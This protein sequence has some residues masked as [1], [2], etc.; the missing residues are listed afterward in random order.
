M[1]HTTS[2]IIKVISDPFWPLGRG[3]CHPGDNLFLQDENVLHSQTNVR[4]GSPVI[5]HQESDFVGGSVDCGL[6]VPNFIVV[7]GS[8]TVGFVF[9]PIQTTLRITS[10]F[11]ILHHCQH[12]YITVFLVHWT[13]HLLFAVI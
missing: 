7:C 5:C 6:G 3:H 2:L 13:V 11:L 4:I 10:S 8:H 9:L 12:S 1:S